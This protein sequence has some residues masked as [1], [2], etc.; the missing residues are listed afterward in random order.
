MKL[1]S[2]ISIIICCYNSASR[3]AETLRN[4]FAVHIPTNFNYELIIVDNNSTDETKL[5]AWD[6]FE[7]YCQ[8][9]IHFRIID[10]NTPGLTSARK[11][12]IQEAKYQLILFW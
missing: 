1:K 7:K 4:I 2:G 3:I 10:E 9:G 5:V 12:G 11:K 6:A 8:R